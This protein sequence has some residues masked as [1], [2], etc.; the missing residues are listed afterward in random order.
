MIRMRTRLACKTLTAIGVLTAVMVIAGPQRA[1]NGE[2]T[3]RS[4]P[5]AK[6]RIVVMIDIGGDPDDR[7]SMVR[8]LLYACDFDVE[9]LCTGFGHGHYEHTRPELI[10]QAVDAYGQVLENLRLH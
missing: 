7:Q 9:G 10:R 5:G 8:F 6:A 3:E 4:L 2:P 1:A